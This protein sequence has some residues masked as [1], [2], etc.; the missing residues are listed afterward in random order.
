VEPRKCSR[1]D[2]SADLEAKSLYHKSMRLTVKDG[3]VGMTTQQQALLFT[4]YTQ[5][6]S[7]VITA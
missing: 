4:P 6:C 2:A 1:D 7:R 3:G 5:V